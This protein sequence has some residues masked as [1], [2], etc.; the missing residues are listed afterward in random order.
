[1][2][3]CHD[4]ATLRAQVAEWKRAGLTVALVP[5]MGN[6]HAGHISLVKRAQ[7]E[8]DKVVVSIFVNP[9]QFGPN[10]DFASYPRTLDAD[11]E[12]LATAQTDL[13]F[14]PSVDVMYPQQNLAWVDIEQLGDTLCGAKRPGHFRGVCTVVTKLFNLVQPDVACFGE[15]DF[16]QLAILRRVTTDLCFPIR[17]I[18]VPTARADTGLALSSR[19][20][21]LTESERLHAAKLQQL[22][23]S[24]RDRILQGERDY[25]TLQAQATQQLNS[26]GFVVDYVA[27]MDANE[28]KPAKN[29][30]K[31][32]LLALAAY[33]GKTRLIDNLSFNV[34]CHS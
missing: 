34:E 13:V 29:G 12:K 22:L 31:Y 19:N 11:R 20:G 6:L 8:A 32:L 23:K 33:L 28:L 24:L 25:A 27:V 9:T 30:D 15:K 17:I 3:T 5:T 10:E 2:K 26:D 16:Q 4:S 18:G 7:Q 1:M 21:Y 14:A